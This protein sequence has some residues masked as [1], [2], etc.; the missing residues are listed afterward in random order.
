MCVF[1]LSFIH[2]LIYQGISTLSK[3]IS[4]F[5]RSRQ[6]EGSCRDLSVD[7]CEHGENKPFESDNSL[8]NEFECQ[9]FCAFYDNPDFHKC[10]FFTYNRQ[11]NFCN[12]FEYD[13]KDYMDFCLK[14]GMT[15][16]PLFEECLDF[17]EPCAVSTNMI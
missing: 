13:V 14:K 3:L 2:L 9:E 5:Y 6:S 10:E 8:N 1:C 7:V 4:F 16:T 11:D 17:D 12:L 15:Q